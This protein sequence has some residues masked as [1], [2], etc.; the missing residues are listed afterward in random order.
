MV[1]PG[2]PRAA[3]RIRRACW[4]MIGIG[5]LLAMVATMAFT[6]TPARADSAVSPD[7]GVFIL[8]GAGYGHGWGMSQYGAYGAAVKGLSWQRI[9]AF[10]Y[11]GTKLSSLRA[12]AS[13]RVWISED[14]DSDLR[15]GPS[16][17]LR[18]S[19]TAG[20][21]Y[22]LPTGKAYQGWRAVRS[23][24]TIKLQYRN[25]KGSWVTRSTR[26]KQGR[27]TFANSARMITVELTGGSVGEFRGQLSVITY[28]S[29]TRSI[30]T[31]T[32]EQ[33]LQSVVPSEMPTSWRA[34]AVRSQAVAARSFAARTQA[35]RGTG[36]SWDV[37]DT[38]S[39]QVYK[40]YA[41]TTQG[42]RT[43]H[44]TA[45]GNAA[46]KATAGK[47]LK[48][49]SSIAF[50]QFSSSNGGHSAPGGYPYLKAKPDPYDSVIT[51][52]AWT[53]TLTT[54]TIAARWP[55]AGTLQQ[56]QV[57]SRDDQGRYGGRVRTVKI[58]GSRSTVSVTAASFRAAFGLRS[59]LF[60]I[61][62]AAAMP[63]AAVGQQAKA[64]GT[65]PRSY[66]TRSR[67]DLLLIAQAGN[68]VRRPVA[69]GGALGAA[70]L[71]GRGGWSGLSHVVNAG[72]WNG[73]GRQDV[74][75]R[76]KQGRLLLYRGKAGGG[77]AALVDMGIKAPYTS[78]TSVGDH[79]RDRRPDLAVVSTAGNLWLLYGNGKTGFAG[80]KKIASGW[81]HQGWLRSPGDFSGDGRPDL[82]T[83]VGG[84]LY[85]HRGTATSF[86]SPVKI[87]HGWNSIS[88]ITSV[89]DFD[90]DKAADIVAGTP[91]GQF[92]LYR[93]TGKG[94]LLDSRT[95]PGSWAGTRFA[96]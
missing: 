77:F 23:G 21:S 59:S 43:V 54:K 50:T 63:A 65:F 67:A 36:S 66:D 64:Y 80:S 8:Q 22:L 95:L 73:D 26:L 91:R 86:S 40:G 90:G 93:G 79:N 44:E 39:C 89:G 82:I 18:V 15:V 24:S 6:A 56:V 20:H 38:T 72:D 10:Y 37:C 47:I 88:T 27:W 5:S 58:I 29:G 46:V 76:T 7:S 35:N 42:R 51:S 33:Y 31:L 75:G 45:A 60:R 69:K 12:G 52:N 19:D 2:L 62:G 4:S 16:A 74:I 71:I 53:K 83:N 34:D 81:A 30:N 70:V 9:L 11:P 92:I 49:G 25:T 55:A 85:L 68:L 28:G 1:I 94:K 41:T 78:I 57:S 48:Y 96:T 84:N 32:M 14:R 87:G 17:G 13:I 61:S 3:A